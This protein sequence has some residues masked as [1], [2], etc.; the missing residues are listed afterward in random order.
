M[1]GTYT[2]KIV[3]QDGTVIVNGLANANVDPIQQVLNETYQSGFW[4]PKDS[5]SAGSVDLLDRE[6]Q[7][8]RDGTLLHWGPMIV[9]D[10]DD[11]EEV[12]VTVPDLSWYFHR[13]QISD[14]RPNALSNAS[15]EGGLTGWTASGVTATSDTSRYAL[16]TKSLK[17]VQAS[18]GV[19]TFEYQQQTKTAGSIGD[20]WM[21][22]GWVYI[23]NSGWVGPAYESRGL[24]ISGIQS[25]VVRDYRFVEIDDATPRDRWVPLEISIW[26][27]PG[28]TWTLETRC[29][30]PGGTVWWDALQLVRMESL[31]HYATDMGTIAGNIVDFIQTPAHGWDDLNISTSDATTGQIL[32][33]H[34]Q[35]A[36][37]VDAAEALN[38][39]EGMGLD[40]SIVV[41]TTTRTFT[42][43]WPRKGT[44]RTASVT[45]SLRT[46]V[47]PTG[48]LSSYKLTEDGASTSTRITVLGEGQGP[49][50]E[51]GYA[52]DPSPLGGLVLGEVINAPAGATINTLQ[53]LAQERLG[54]AKYLVRVLEVT[55]LPSDATT[56]TTCVVGDTVDVDISDGWAVASGDW[57]IV[58]KTID[59]DTDTA[60]FVLNELLVAS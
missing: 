1:A 58:S 48:N 13:R 3:E 52:T 31:S 59:P 2:V 10:A 42:S 50:R 21:L 54:A 12:H 57:R 5:A 23:Q 55:G 11:G 51:E 25:G 6:C 28:E 19:D 43:Y 45:L 53:V 38:E 22:K 46:A 9:G 60:S 15:F 18:A 47:N 26:I 20:V 17:L 27:P 34:Y 7:I 32:D 44:D 39:F 30:G 29:Y 56:L 4:F 37:H 33:R 16:G 35:Y 14:S 40:W 8:F 49:A 41:T 24:F 36:D